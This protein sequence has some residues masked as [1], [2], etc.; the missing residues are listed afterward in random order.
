VTVE[1][2]ESVVPGDLLLNGVGFPWLVLDKR[3]GPFQSTS[4]PFLFK[5]MLPSGLISWETGIRA[6]FLSRSR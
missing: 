3:K 2:M 6:S 5:V 4:S 1:E